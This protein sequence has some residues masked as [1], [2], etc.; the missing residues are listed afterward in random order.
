MFLL[1]EQNGSP[2]SEFAVFNKDLG[3]ESIAQVMKIVDNCSKFMKCER[4]SQVVLEPL[5]HN[6]MD[7]TNLISLAVPEMVERWEY[8]PNE[9]DDEFP[10]L[11]G[12]GRSSGSVWRCMND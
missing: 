3:D 6:V 10:L 12:E 5:S 11:F 1:I 7:G 9:P 8:L 2:V 4:E